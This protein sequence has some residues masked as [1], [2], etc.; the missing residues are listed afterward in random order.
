M[1]LLDSDCSRVGSFSFVGSTNC[2]LKTDR[3]IDSIIY[4][5]SLESSSVSLCLSS[6]R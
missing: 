4:A 5:T 2:V 3:L 6:L 1:A